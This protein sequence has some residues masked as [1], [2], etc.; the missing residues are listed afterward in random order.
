MYVRGSN[1]KLPKPNRYMFSTDAGYYIQGSVGQG[2]SSMLKIL[3]ACVKL[4]WEF[5]APRVR[6]QQRVRGRGLMVV[7]LRR[8]LHASRSSVLG[9]GLFEIFLVTRQLSSL[10]HI[11]ALTEKHVLGTGGKR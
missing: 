6:T 2:I 4:G 11:L 9:G 5:L 7:V 1:R 10:L 3:D 8:S